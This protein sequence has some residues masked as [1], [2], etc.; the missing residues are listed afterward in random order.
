M[1]VSVAHAISIPAHVDAMARVRAQ[2]AALLRE[3]SWP[4]ETSQRIVLAGC[5][6]I[7]NAI[8]HGSENDDLVKIDIEVNGTLARLKVADSGRQG[9]SLPSLDV[10]PPPPSAT[11]GRGLLIMLHMSD[12]AEIRPTGRGTE[13]VLEFD[14]R[15]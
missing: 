9:S 4:G 5:E 8:E 11:R 3:Q 12:R 7:T 10:E 2:L 1:G 6:A 14:R 13:V 15:A